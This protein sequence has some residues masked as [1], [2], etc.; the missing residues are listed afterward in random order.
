MLTQASFL[1][2]NSNLNRGKKMRILVDG[3]ASPVIKIVEEIAE[4]YDIKLIVFFDINHNI[5]LEYGQ[6]IRVDQSF[7]SVDIEIYNEC[8]EGDIVITQDY[9]LANLV[10]GN[11]AFVLS[12]TGKRYTDKNIQYLLMKRHLHARI[13]RAGGRHQTQKKRTEADDLR[14]RKSLKKLIKTIC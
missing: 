8:E 1:K 3:D 13:R 14:F 12:S 11:G 9:G 10:L 2:L 4:E 7:Q 5:Q 6:E